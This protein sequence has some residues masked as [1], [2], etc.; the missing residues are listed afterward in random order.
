MLGASVV[1]YRVARTVQAASKKKRWNKLRG[2][3]VK[4]T[5][6]HRGRGKESV[7]WRMQ[8]IGCWLQNKSN[9]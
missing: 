7:A 5:Q 1:C 2:I 9:N 6:K 4:V 3:D 8:N